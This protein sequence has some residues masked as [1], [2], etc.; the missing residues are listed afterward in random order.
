MIAFILISWLLVSIGILILTLH[1]RPTG[2]SNLLLGS[3]VSVFFI[4]HAS[5]S[6][7]TFELLEPTYLFIDVIGPFGFA[8]GPLFY[9]SLKVFEER[10]DKLLRKMILHGIPFYV[11][12]VFYLFYI[13][14]YSIRFHFQDFISPLWYVS[15]CVSWSMYL[16]FLIIFMLKD[17][18]NKNIFKVNV[19]TLMLFVVGVS[20]TTLFLIGFSGNLDPIG[21]RKNSFIAFMFIHSLLWYKFLLERV[22]K[23]SV[24]SL[25]TNSFS[26]EI[27]DLIYHSSQ[28]LIP[29]E[30][31]STSFENKEDSENVI[32][33]KIDYLNADFN[34]SSQA[35]ALNISAMRLSEIIKEETGLTYNNYINKKRIEYAVVLL[36]ENKDLD[37]VISAC[38]FLSKSSFYRNFKKFT[39]HTPSEFIKQVVR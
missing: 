22:K 1:L 30:D 24:N 18:V 8:Y 20:F 9:F 17:K 33:H 12:T 37:E 39:I 14:S 3:I 36:K 13:N 15:V 4:V 6:F 16:V 35:S 32:L 31:F 2:D 29:E 5:V 34:L 23:Y 10:E 11:A 7:L 28:E 25:K 27:L 21:V 19:N 38:G 26:S